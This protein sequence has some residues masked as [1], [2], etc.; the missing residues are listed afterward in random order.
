MGPLLL[1]LPLK[2][3]HAGIL[4]QRWQHTTISNRGDALAQMRR[5]AALHLGG[6][7]AGASGGAGAR[8]RGEW[9]LLGQLL[10]QLLRCHAR[11]MEP[12]ACARLLD[13]LQGLCARVSGGSGG[14]GNHTSAYP[15]DTSKTRSCAKNAGIRAPPPHGRD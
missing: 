3:L 14:G 1:R 12:L 6:D 4:L 9:V 2:T 10:G 5:A 11:L 8:G 13:R 15:C 7:G